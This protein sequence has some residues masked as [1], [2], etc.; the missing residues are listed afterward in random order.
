MSKRGKTAADCSRDILLAHGITDVSVNK[1][2]GNL[3]DHY[4]PRNNTVNLSDAV[5]SSTSVAAIGVAAHECGH[6]IQHAESY[7]PVKLRTAMVPITNFGSSLSLPLIMISL[8]SGL[9][10]LFIAGIL[11]YSLSTF[12]QLVTL[13]VEFNASKRAINELRKSNTMSEE[14]LNGVKKVL[15][16]AALTYVAALFSAIVTLIRPILM[17]KRRN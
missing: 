8:F 2:G 7:F 1:V 15:T 16:A 5:Y 6:A 9:E 13:P 12:F 14:E 10:A 11:L 17:S 4:D 3:S